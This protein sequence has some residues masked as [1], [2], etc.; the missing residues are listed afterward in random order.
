MATRKRLYHPDE[1]REKIRTSQ[2]INR[3]QDF[4]FGKVEL[5]KSQVTAILGLL[6]KT[7]P[8]LATVTHQGD[9]NAPIPLQLRGSDVHG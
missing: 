2:L 1:V 9:A 8:D 6:R 5:S 3:L 4:G 7:I